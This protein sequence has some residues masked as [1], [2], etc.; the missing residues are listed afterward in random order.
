MMVIVVYDICT[1]DET[2]EYRLRKI[3]RICRNVGHNIQ[4]SVFE[5]VVTPA[6][7]N[8]LRQAITDVIDPLVDKVKI[9]HMGSNWEKSIES[10]GADDG[11]DPK[12]AL[13]V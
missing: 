8:Y 10:L 2:G 6:E 9:Y 4:G 1:S 12:G 11:Y 13:I 7:L 5:C 3:N